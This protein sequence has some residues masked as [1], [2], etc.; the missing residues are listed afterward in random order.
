MALSLRETRAVSGLV[1]VL[2][3]FL[4]G[5]GRATWKGHVNFGTVAAK[6]GLGDFWPGGSK[7]PAINA[8]IS[9]TLDQRRGQFE[10]LIMEIVRS[11]VVYR[12]KQGCPIAMAEIDALNGHIYEIGFKFPQLWDRGF[13]D[14]LGQTTAERGRQALREADVQYQESSQRATRS[15]ELCRLKEEFLQLTAQ[16][17]RNAAGLALE[18]LL[19]RLFA[20]CELDPRSPFRVVGEQIDGSF[21]LDGQ[22]YLVEVKWEKEP[23]S[24]GPLLIFRGKIEGKSTFTRGVFIAL[25]DVSAEAR[26]AIT[27]GKSP[28]FIVV[29]GYDL[30]MILSEGIALTEFL[31]KRIRLLA[32]EGR[33]CVPFAEIR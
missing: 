18:G 25:N 19:N 8:L 6:V 29:N 5:S 27:Q 22:V 15:E 16:T 24:E 33:V 20:I 13:R 2:Y 1:D 7:K 17:D 9:Q 11:A 10:T 21:L 23:L 28:S 26:H 31:R 14:S 12:E 32:E 4:P 30:M 3:D